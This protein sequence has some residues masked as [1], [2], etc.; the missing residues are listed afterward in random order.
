MTGLPPSTVHA[1]QLLLQRRVVISWCARVGAAA[2][3]AWQSVSLLQ[4]SSLSGDTVIHNAACQCRASSEARSP[5]EELKV[6]LDAMNSMQAPFYY[7]YL[8]LSAVDRRVG[9]QGV[10]QF[11][12]IVNT[13][14]K[15]R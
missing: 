11:S 10:V 8:L 14:D 1:C 12:A 2:E 3:I 15:V 4:Q 7:R 5:L 13:M 6:A 9:G